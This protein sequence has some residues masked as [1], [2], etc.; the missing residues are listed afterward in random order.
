M[1]LYM[2]VCECVCV[3]VLVCLCVFERVLEYWFVTVE[4]V[5]VAFQSCHEQVRG[6]VSRRR[7]VRR[8]GQCH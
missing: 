2:R 6:K 7:H 3:C 1:Y 4:R 5:G 8:R